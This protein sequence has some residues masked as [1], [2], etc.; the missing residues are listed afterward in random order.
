MAEHPVLVLR[1]KKQSSRP[2]LLV[3]WN[4][5]KRHNSL[6]SRKQRY[7]IQAV[8]AAKHLL[9]WHHIVCRS[10]THTPAAYSNRKQGIV[11]VFEK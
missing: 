3:K 9:A 11:S 1:C 10:Y 2:V 7:K 6:C 4:L 5:A 8:R